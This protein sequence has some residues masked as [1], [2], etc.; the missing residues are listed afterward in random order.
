MNK[1]PERQYIFC[2]PFLDEITRIR[3]AV[4][5]EMA[6]PQFRNGRKID[7][8]N[9]HLLNG[10]SI[11]ASHT[12]FANATDDTNEYIQRGNYTL[13][14][15]E[16]LDLIMD[17]N[18]AVG[19]NVTKEDIRLLL[20]EGFIKADLYGRVTWNKE[21]Y[22]G[23]KYSNVERVAKAGNLYYLNESFLC[24]M[25]SPDIFQLFDEVYVLTYLFDGSLFAPYLQYH[26]NEYKKFGI[27]RNNGEYHLC[28]Y[29]P[30]Q[31]TGIQY[32]GLIDILDS[33]VMNGYKAGQLSKKWFQNS[34]VKERQALKDRIYNFLRNMNHA[35][36]NAIMWTCPKDYKKDLKNKGCNIVWRMTEEEKNLPKRER[37]RVEKRLQCFVP[38]NA[39]ASNEFR[40]RS[41][42]VYAANLYTNPYVRRFFELK[43][44][45]DGTN[46]MV[47]DDMFALS[48]MIQW[49]FRSSIRDGKQIKIYI[50]SERMR[51][52]LESWI[53]GNSELFSQR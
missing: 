28:Q 27:E 7:D 32:K 47:N 36:S 43:N 3:Q 22:L 11:V 31:S 44:K 45:A 2:T 16:T 6:E 14:L 52:L 37:E 20:N 12:T 26:G 21:S 15:D 51:E 18:D 4:C 17:F 24:W 8:L 40:D 13:I 42:L 23:A 48:N 5:F 19:D 38:L 29:N 46:I 50:P 41:V 30:L 33:P 34:S 1:N 49:I 39:R 35:S 10:D 25:F 9:N 53:S